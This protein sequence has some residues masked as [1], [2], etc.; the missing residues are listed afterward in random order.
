MQFRNIS[1]WYFTLLDNVV[2]VVVVDNVTEVRQCIL[3]CVKERA[4]EREY[5]QCEDTRFLVWKYDCIV[6]SLLYT[7]TYTEI[8]VRTSIYVCMYVCM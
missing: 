4:R 8:H 1:F 3:L 5:N 7:H 2:V 6:Y